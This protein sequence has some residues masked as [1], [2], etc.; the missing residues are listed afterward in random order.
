M[1]TIETGFGGEVPLYVG[2]LAVG[3]VAGVVTFFIQLAEGGSVP[4]GILRGVV[5][6]VGVAV[7]FY[8]GLLVRAGL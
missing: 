7:A 6:A 8:I 2:A 3:V 5:S 1:Q 4:G